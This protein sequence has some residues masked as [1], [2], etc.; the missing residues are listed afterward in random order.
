MASVR[1]AVPAEPDAPDPTWSE[2]ESGLLTPHG[3]WHPRAKLSSRWWLLYL[4][5]AVCLVFA[6]SLA[7]ILLG[8][9]LDRALAPA[10]S[11]PPSCAVRPFGMRVSVVYNVFL[12]AARDWRPLYRLQLNDLDGCGLSQSAEIHVAL[13]APAISWFDASTERALDEAESIGRSILPR[14]HYHRS[15]G[16]LYEYPGIK[17]AY[18]L[19]VADPSR[20]HVLLYFHS[21]G[22]VNGG[23][24]RD[25]WNALLTNAV[26]L[27]WRTVLQRFADDEGVN[28]AGYSA[29]ANG[30]IWFN[31]WYVRASYARTLVKPILTQRRHYYEDWI[32]RV[33][34]PT[35]SYVP[36]YTI[37]NI[38][39]ERL[40]HWSGAAD[41]LSLCN[42][43][44]KHELGF[45]MEPDTMARCD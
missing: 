42:G 22:M 13:S 32:G 37:A 19:A 26:I 10:P 8:N 11:P 31:F 20:S 12:N 30:W 40:G 36:D 9:R 44:V 15:R 16:N 39:V 28:K 7:G 5:L 33:A 2:D 27:P 25:K 21:K 24:G 4:S 45:H 43:N 3:R 38:T 41:S 35:D 6:V 34:D 14:A 17:L 23:D 1:V 18:E 29:A